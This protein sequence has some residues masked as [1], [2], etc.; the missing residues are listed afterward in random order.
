MRVYCDE[1]KAVKE[2]YDK[3]SGSVKNG[4]YIFGA[5]LGGYGV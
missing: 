2:Q 1:M 4:I 5:G 3:I